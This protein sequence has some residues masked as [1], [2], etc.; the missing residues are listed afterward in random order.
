MRPCSGHEGT[1]RGDRVGN[2]HEQLSVAT[3]FSCGWAVSGYDAVYLALAALFEGVWLTADARAA[4][5]VRRKGLVR[6]LGKLNAPPRGGSVRPMAVHRERQPRFGEREA[7]VGFEPLLDDD[8]LRRRVEQRTEARR[9]RVVMW[10]VF[11]EPEPDTA[12]RI[13]PAVSRAGR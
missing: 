6:I 7:A 2:G 3:D 4:A 13:T 5:T 11:L 1:Q 8:A 12:C 10:S 9:S